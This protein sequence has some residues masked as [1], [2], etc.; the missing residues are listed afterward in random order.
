M[1]GHSGGGQAANDGTING[2]SSSNVR[3][4]KIDMGI[5]GTGRDETDESLRQAR[6]DVGVFGRNGDVEMLRKEQVEPEEDM[7]KQGH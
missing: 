6:T 4:P 1:W 3:I 5:L 2:E 7:D